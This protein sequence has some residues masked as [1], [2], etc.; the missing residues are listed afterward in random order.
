MTQHYPM[1]GFNPI[2][3]HRPL[4]PKILRAKIPVTSQDPA[5]S[6]VQP[7]WVTVCLSNCSFLAFLI[8][9]ALLLNVLLPFIPSLDLQK[10][11]TAFQYRSPVQP[12]FCQRPTA[13]CWED[14]SPGTFVCNTKISNWAR[15]D[16]W[17]A[18][19]IKTDSVQR[20][21]LIPLYVIYMAAYSLFVL[22]VQGV[23]N[24]T[25]G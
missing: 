5:K 20:D 7:T 22:P 9:L 14:S 11:V 10:P 16:L 21:L 25:M 15:K 23:V 19:I 4:G 3:Q 1:E 18:H 6:Q 13:L 2:L 8:T 24:C 17:G 12:K